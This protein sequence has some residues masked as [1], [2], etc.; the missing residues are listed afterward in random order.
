MDPMTL[1]VVRG[2][3][4]QAA[5]EM[6]LHLIHAAISPIISEMH[7]CAHGIFAAS[8]GET[9]AQGGYGLPMFLANMQYTVQNL[10]ESIQAEGGFQ[11]GDIWILN[12]PY[13][14]GSHLQD[15]TL[16]CPYFV[17]G[18]LFAELVQTLRVGRVR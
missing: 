18:K 13:L 3:L 1:A 2:A 9:I 15:V 5:D 6:D 14:S 4:H 8:N 12:D 16:V 17:E 7:D 10:L 11:P